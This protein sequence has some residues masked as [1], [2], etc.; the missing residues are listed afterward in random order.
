MLQS[1]ECL[2]ADELWLALADLTRHSHSQQSFAPRDILRRAQEM[3]GHSRSS[4]PAHLEIHNLANIP[5]ESAD[6]SLMVRLPDGTLRLFRPGDE[7]HP[8]RRG[9]TYPDQQYLPAELQQLVRWYLDSYIPTRR[10][11]AVDPVIAMLG[12]ARGAWDSAGGGEAFV[13][14]LRRTLSDSLRSRQEGRPV[15]R[16]EV[17]PARSTEVWD[18]ILLH[19]GEEFHTVTNL[20]FKY[21]VDGNGIWFFRGGKRI[22]MRLSRSEVN[23]ALSRRNVLRTTDLSDL[24]DYPY[25]FALLRDPRIQGWPGSPAEG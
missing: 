21:E 1:V 20:P 15:P 4:W 12:V 22:D 5:P 2:P 24:R 6:F 18:R 23:K 10:R 9:R 11:E 8:L 13:R 17:D 3:F 25:L 7:R 16:L 14:S 19:Q